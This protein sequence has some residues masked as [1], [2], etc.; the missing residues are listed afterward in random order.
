MAGKNTNSSDTSLVQGDATATAN[1]AKRLTKTLT[2]GLGNPFGWDTRKKALVDCTEDQRKAIYIGLRATSRILAQAINIQNAREYVR[3]IMKIPDE[4]VAKFKP[5]NTAIRRELEELGLPVEDVSGATLSQTYA[6]GVKPDFA[7]DHRTRLLFTGERQLPT[8]R[9]DG[10]HPILGRGNETQI[11]RLD[12]R[13]FLVVQV[14]SANWAGKYGLPSGWIAFPAKIKPR[15][16]TM[17]GQFD[18]TI[19][20]E[21]VLKNSRIC[22][23]P[24]KRGNRWL[25]QVVVSYVPEPF[26]TLNPATIMGV[27]LGVSVPACLHIRDHGKP[28]QWAMKIGRGRE[29]LNTRGLIHS[30]IVRIIRALRSKDSPLDPEARRV[31]QAK[32]KELRKRE[33]RVMKTASQIIAARI[34]EV[35]RRNGA[36]C[37]QMEALSPDIKDDQPWLA[38]NWAPGMVVDAVRWQAQQ[39][40]AKLELI[41][42]AY[43]SQRCSK[44]GH[45][46]RANRPKGRKGAAYF[47]C[48]KCSYQDDADKNA[49]RNISTPGIA[50]L[51]QV[52]I[53][54][55]PNG[56][57][58]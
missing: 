23:N 42:P 7:G 43:T 35:A 40:G 33:K 55:S 51:I 50:D 31:A 28:M 18:R 58:R 6:L 13:Y 45:I 22:R 4:V 25:G 30:D 27:D 52:N 49:A 14:F 48:V 17:A 44:C 47:Q 5:S 26:K 57:V 54:K 34:A 24:R 37:W 1:D 12:D 38:R 21:W 11:L 16:K 10:T 41:N 8:H 36:G 39:L 19:E 29:M 32:L 15:D 20:G 46:S 3:R 9:I 53:Q 2:F 56:E